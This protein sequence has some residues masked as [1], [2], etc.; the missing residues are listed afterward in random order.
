MKFSILIASIFLLSE[1]IHAKPLTCLSS[2]ASSP[3]AYYCLAVD[4]STPTACQQCA[5]GVKYFCPTSPLLSTGSWKRGVKVLSNCATI[6]KYTAIATFPNGGYSGHAAVFISC[7][8]AT[9]RIVVFDQ[10]AGKKWST[11]DLWNI[12]NGISNDPTQFY[13]VEV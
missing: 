2:S 3:V 9:Q 8:A 10:Y 4:N 5:A 1:F 11:R 13:V 7:N 12:G 6:P